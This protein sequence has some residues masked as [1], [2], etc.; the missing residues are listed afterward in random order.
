MNFSMIELIFFIFVRFLLSF[1][2]NFALDELRVPPVAG[3]LWNTTQYRN[4]SLV[5]FTVITIFLL[6]VSLLY[7]LFLVS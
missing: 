7:L 4:Y 3:S 1:K 6:L 2:A 5:V